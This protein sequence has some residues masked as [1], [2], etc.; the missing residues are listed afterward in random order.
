[1]PV[2]TKKRYGRSDMLAIVLRTTALAGALVAV[3]ALPASLVG[4]IAQALEL[5]RAVTA[6]LVLAV[7]SAGFI[8]LAVLCIVCVGLA[9][10]ADRA[11]D[12]LTER[13]G[14]LTQP[15]AAPAVAGAGVQLTFGRR[16]PGAGLV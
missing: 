8:G 15:P 16:R 5:S 4:G 11:A 7:W 6:G 12:V 14:R 10:Q 1:M 3:A 9:L 13:V 2:T